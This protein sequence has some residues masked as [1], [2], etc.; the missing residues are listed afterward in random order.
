MTYSRVI[1]RDLFNESKLLK[2]LGRLVLLIYDGLAPEGLTFKHDGEPFVVEQDLS[3]GGLF[4]TTLQVWYRGKPLQLKSP[5][6][7]REPYPLLLVNG[8]G[9]EFEVFN[10]SGN[11]TPEFLTALEHAR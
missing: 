1:P 9:E 4:C 2:C 5:Y 11:F 7:S 8:D 10:G 6:N 3:D